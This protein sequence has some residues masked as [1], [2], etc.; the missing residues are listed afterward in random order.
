MKFNEA[1]KL[2]KD[3]HKVKLPS[4]GG[5]WCWDEE[6]QTVMMHYRQK[7]SDT[8]SEVLDIR[9]TLRVEYTLTN[10]MSD[11]WVLA[12]EENCPVLGGVNTFS[13]SEALKYLKRGMKVARKNWNGKNQYV[14]L[15]KDL[16]FVTEAD[17]SDLNPNGDIECT[18][19]N[20]VYVYDCL[21]IRTADRKIQLGWLATQSDLLAEDWVFAE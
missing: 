13:F 11:D 5:Y 7:D 10:I 19:D 21:A 8:D 17:L 6:K 18:E 14:F 15:A 20:M 16:E 2:M 1:F 12:T 9:E 3:G 4:W